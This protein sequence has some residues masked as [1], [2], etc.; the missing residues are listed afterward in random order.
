MCRW[1]AAVQEEERAPPPARVAVM[2]AAPGVPILGHMAL[3][4][5]ICN[6]CDDIVLASVWGT[7][8]EFFVVVVVLSGWQTDHAAC[9]QHY[10][11]TY[12]YISKTCC[13]VVVILFSIIIRH[14]S[15]CQY[16]RI[17]QQLKVFLAVRWLS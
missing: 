17:H 11:S 9:H 10:V 3:V 1:V 7:K 4:M 12:V 2:G 13:V 16:W 6:E 5:V 15:S 14:T 8:C